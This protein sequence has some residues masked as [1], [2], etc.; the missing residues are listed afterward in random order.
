MALCKALQ[1]GAAAVALRRQG[2]KDPSRFLV[3]EIAVEVGD[4]K[5][6][7]VIECQKFSAA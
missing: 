2:F 3:R 1:Q 4:D 6:K 5:P 7:P